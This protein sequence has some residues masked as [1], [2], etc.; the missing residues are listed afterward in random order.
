MKIERTGAPAKN[1]TF[2][3]IEQGEVFYVYSPDEDCWFSL[4][5]SEPE[6]YIKTRDGVYNLRTGGRFGDITSYRTVKKVDATVVIN[7]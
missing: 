2:G 4:D 7:D 5:G 1:P 6:L 3:D